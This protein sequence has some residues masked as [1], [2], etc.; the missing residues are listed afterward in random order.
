M[1]FFNPKEEVLDIQL[2]QHG[3]RLLSIGKMEPV[4]YAFYD[5]DILYDVAYANGSEKQR[6]S[7]ERILDD[8]PR[9]KTQYSFTTVEKKPDDDEQN[10]DGR[11]T[12]A[13]GKRLFFGGQPTGG[14]KIPMQPAH[15]RDY[16]GSSCLGKAS[17]TNQYAPSWRANLLHGEIESQ[18]CTGS[19]TAP[20]VNTPQLNSTIEYK[21]VA[22]DPVAAIGT[23]HEKAGAEGGDEAFVDSRLAGFME[24]DDGSKI[25]VEDDYILLDL[26]EFNVDFKNENFDIEVYEILEES[27]EQV[28]TNGNMSTRPK[29]EKMQQLYFKLNPMSAMGGAAIMDPMFD[30]REVEDPNCVEYYLDIKTDREI[31]P[32]IMCKFREAIKSRTFLDSLFNCPDEEEG[33]MIRVDYG[34]I[35]SDPEEECD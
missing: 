3:K 33:D 30:E 19:N 10:T 2:T 22:Y 26:E 23:E 7:K 1:T 34:F 20:W 13:K 14:T 9:P 24:Y 6:E 5:G 27:E 12:T 17:L 21:S 29:V 18:Y 8:T 16:F 4:Y 28:I 11:P 32:D 31:D 15:E 25:V 35:A